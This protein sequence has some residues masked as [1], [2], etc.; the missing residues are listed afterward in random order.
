MVISMVSR[1]PSGSETMTFKKEIACKSCRARC[2][3]PPNPAIDLCKQR[4]ESAAAIIA[5]VKERVEKAQSLL[6]Y[7][8][9]VKDTI[10]AILKS[11]E[12]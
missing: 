12:E 1:M 2:T 4:L 6:P 3:E 11:L 9:G 8:V 10:D 7:N 5:L